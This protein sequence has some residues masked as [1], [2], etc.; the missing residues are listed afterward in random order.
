M[1]P[2]IDIIDIYL[3]CGFSNA[4]HFHRI[5]KRLSGMTPNQYRKLHTRDTSGT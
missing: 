4:Q 5:F 3:D 1:N 2:K